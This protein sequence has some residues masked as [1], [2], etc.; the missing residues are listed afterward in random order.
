MA[1]AHA[2]AMPP[3]F[4]PQPILLEGRHV[5]LEPL[6]RRHLPGLI[7]AAHDPEVFQYFVTPP[8]GN[9]TEMT[10]WLEGILKG[11]AAGTDVGW[12]TVRKSDNR[13]V[14]ATTY[15]DIRRVNRGLEIGNTW[16]AK[17]AWRTPINTEAKLLQLTHAFEKLGAWRVQLKTDER[18]AR[19]RAAIAR[20]GCTFEGIL[21]R[22]Q[23]RSDGFVRNTA[24]FSL[25][26]SEWPAAKAKLEAKLGR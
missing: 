6:E 5:R 23:L 20:L 13:V 16:L 2:G 10:K 15:L 14:G 17:E 26:D 21:R 19:S 3:V 25:L 4:D 11:Q 22:Y 7:A 12:A 18:N 24:M 9:E 8:L 1:G